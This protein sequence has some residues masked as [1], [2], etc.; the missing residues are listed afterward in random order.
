MNDIIIKK[1]EIVD[2]ECIQNLNND[3]FELEY[4]SFDPDL[5]LGWPYTTEGKEYFTDII[6]H[7]ICYISLK[8][9][10]IVG[11]LA[12]RLKIDNSYISKITAELE[13]MCI[14]DSCRGLGI[15]NLL[16]NE[17]IKV[18]KQNDIERIIVTASSKNSNAIEFY[19]KQGFTDYNR[20]LKI[21]I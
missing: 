13:N 6:E 21:N 15:G 18:C 20:T 19:K 8:D 12:G 11:Y 5:I 1:A 10:V 2:L 9:K 4:A 14:L 16:M 17:F 7:N 3:L